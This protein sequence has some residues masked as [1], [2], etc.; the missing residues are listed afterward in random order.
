MIQDGKVT[1]IEMQPLNQNRSIYRLVRDGESVI[2]TPTREGAIKED[3]LNGFGFDLALNMEGEFQEGEPVRC[4]GRT[5]N[6]SNSQCEF[7][8]YCRKGTKVNMINIV[9]KELEFEGTMGN[10]QEGKLYQPHGVVKRGLFQENNFEDIVEGIVQ[11][12]ADSYY[13]PEELELT[14]PSQRTIWLV[15]VGPVDLTDKGLVENACEICDRIGLPFLEI[16]YSFNR[17]QGSKGRA[18]ELE[19]SLS[20][21]GKDDVIH[22]ILS[23]EVEEAVAQ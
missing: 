16:K 13:V 7:E 5:P 11:D 14:A 10:S 17:L 4:S 1:S 15:Q 18:A 2:E 22:I 3:V 6:P 12:G 19:G 20:K 8:V 21:P 23:K 9:I